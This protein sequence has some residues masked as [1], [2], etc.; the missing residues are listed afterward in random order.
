MARVGGTCRRW[1]ESEK[2]KKET[3][4]QSWGPQMI[5]WPVRASQLSQPAV[6]E[7]TQQMKEA[8]PVKI[9]EQFTV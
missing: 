5:L 8:S 1:T 6:E 3:H 9:N 2:G 4:L 7:S